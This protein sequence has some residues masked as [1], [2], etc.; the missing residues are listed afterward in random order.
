[1]RKIIVITGTPGVGKTTIAKKLARSLKNVEYISANELIKEKKLFG[2][3]AMDGAKIAKLKPLQ[4][5]IEKRI[6]SSKKNIVLVEGHLLCE[7]KI[8]GA[9]AVVLREHLD[10]LRQRM[11]KRGYSSRKINDNIIS[12]ATDYCGIRASANY[13]DTYEFLSGTGATKKIAK[14]INNGKTKKEDIE[15]LHELDYYL[16]S[17]RSYLK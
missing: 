12:E 11:E 16:K 3:T 5:S 2:G 4:K 15:L 8:K 14:L 6:N 7:I 13:K 10:T 1:M 17:D 9:V